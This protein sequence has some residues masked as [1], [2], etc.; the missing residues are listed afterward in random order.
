M[1]LLEPELARHCFVHTPHYV[2]EDAVCP[3]LPLH[4]RAYLVISV[5]FLLLATRKRFFC[6]LQVNDFFAS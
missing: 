1:K 3:P 4:H 6:Q 2:G 5:D